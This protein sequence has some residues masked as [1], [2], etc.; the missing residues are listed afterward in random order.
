[1]KHMPHIS[2][3]GVTVGGP[4][5]SKLCAAGLRLCLVGLL[6]GLLLPFVAI[7]G[8][9]ALEAAEVE[10]ML[11][12]QNAPVGRKRPGLVKNAPK[13]L[14][15]T[16]IQSLVRPHK[17]R[18]HINRH[19][20]DYGWE[21]FF[22]G[23]KRDTSLSVAAFPDGSTVSVGYTRSRGNGDADILLLRLDARGRLIW[24]KT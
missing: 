1:M 13:N 7:V 2:G 11:G 3:F 20:A 24:Q 23:R 19:L 6:S 17:P 8:A 16:R 21:R 14:I 18:R 12:T 5:S 10:N 15:G 4:S 9:Q 22:G